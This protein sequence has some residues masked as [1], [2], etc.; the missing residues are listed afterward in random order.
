MRRFD[1]PLSSYRILLEG[2]TS[3][4]RPSVTAVELDEGILSGE[5]SKDMESKQCQEPL[6]RAGRIRGQ[7]W[8]SCSIGRG[9]QCQLQCGNRFV[10][11]F[12]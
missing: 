10:L 2:H 9:H 6:A 3:F 1:G 7:K 11:R 5:H 12:A 4:G 8:V